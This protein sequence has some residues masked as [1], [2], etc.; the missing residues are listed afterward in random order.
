MCRMSP[1]SPIVLMLL[2]MA[3]GGCSSPGTTRPMTVA[4]RDKLTGEP[5]ASA[6][7]DARALSFFAPMDVPFAGRDAILDSSPPKL[8]RGVTGPDGTVRLAIVAGH[9]VQVIVMAAGYDV[10]VVDLD[11]HPADDGLPSAWFDSD[12]GLEPDQPRRMQVRFLP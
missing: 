8:V 5:V 4:V 10:Q 2:L 11:R 3:A 6:Q 1:S 7:V 12:L 9:P